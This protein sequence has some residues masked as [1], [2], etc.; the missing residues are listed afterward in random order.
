MTGDL[1]V[2]SFIEADMSF[3]T[4]IADILENPV[5]TAASSAMLRWL[6]EYHT[7]LLHWSGNEQTTLAEH[8]RL[9]ERIAANDAEGAV[10][11]MRSHLD[12]SRDMFAPRR[13]T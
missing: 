2:R 4:A 9:I 12:R 1:D 8:A 11:E 6:Q 7:S 5:V 13:T 3:H 10:D